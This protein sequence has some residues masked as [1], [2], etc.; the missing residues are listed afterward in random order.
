MLTNKGDLSMSKKASNKTPNDQRS[1][2]RNP[3]NTDYKHNADNRSRQLNQ[4]RPT[5]R[6]SRKG[7]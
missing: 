5:P 6:S 7:S 4:E 2:V 3:N 1:N